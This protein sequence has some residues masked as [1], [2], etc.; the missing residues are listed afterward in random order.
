MLQIEKGMVYKLMKVFYCICKMEEQ[1]T[2]FLYE[3]HRFCA[4]TDWW[5]GIKEKFFNGFNC[6]EG[7]VIDV[8]GEKSGSY[9]RIRK[10]A[11][12][13]MLLFET[14]EAYVT[15]VKDCKDGK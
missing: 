6:V 10:R 3:Q 1:E 7:F 5:E 15:Y 11:V 8:E 13:S 2:S 14:K 9:V 12:T 4:L